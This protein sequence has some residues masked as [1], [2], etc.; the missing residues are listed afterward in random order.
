MAPLRFIDVRSRYFVPGVV[1][2]GIVAVLNFVWMIIICRRWKLPDGRK[3][4][5]AYKDQ[6][7][8]IEEAKKG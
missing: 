1:V 7:R 4:L 3:S 2:A 5:Q 8:A 6:Q